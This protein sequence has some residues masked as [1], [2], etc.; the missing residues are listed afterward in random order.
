MTAP[1][2]SFPSHRLPTEELP[3]SVAQTQDSTV[4]ND[5]DK[6]IIARSITCGPICLNLLVGVAGFEVN[7]LLILNSLVD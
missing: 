4:R 1:Q 2:T 7:L 5:Y 3:S 6:L